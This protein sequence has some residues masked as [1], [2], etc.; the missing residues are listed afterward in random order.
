MVAAGCWCNREMRERARQV[1]RL[2]LL[3]SLSKPH[4]P[5]NIHR[6]KN[7]QA[8]LKINAT[9][10]HEV[11]SRTSTII[12]T[13]PENTSIYQL[14]C[15]IASAKR[16]TSK[17]PRRNKIMTAAFNQFHRMLLSLL[18]GSTFFLVCRMPAVSVSALS[19]S[20]KGY[21]F[22][23]SSAATTTTTANPNSE[24][25][26]ASDALR[27][28]LRQQSYVPDGL[29]LEQYAKIKNDELTKNRSKNFG[30]WGPRF[31]IVDGDPDSNWFNLPS[32]WTGGY[33]AN[34][35]NNGKQKQQLRPDSSGLK[36]LRK[37]MGGVVHVLAVYLRRYALAYVM[38]LLATHLLLNKSS[39]FPSKNVMSMTLQKNY[40]P[41]WTLVVPLAI[42]KL[43]N[44][45]VCILTEK[46]VLGDKMLEK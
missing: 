22:G 25:V 23:I 21:H 36:V 1:A 6:E 20:L 27:R 16:T 8:A 39:L 34:K 29:T 28:G 30:A 44:L 14:S 13:G 41:L 15:S 38:L 35:L 45:M 40:W 43:S 7:A 9:C 4:T 12:Y 31:Q 19:S 18:V 37:R 42:L 33:D 3:L 26:T 11:C 10:H 2:A 5:H 46:K 32:L 17:K 24:K